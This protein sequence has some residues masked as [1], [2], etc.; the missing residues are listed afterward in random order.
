MNTCFR[1]CVHTCMCIQV[2]ICAYARV[3]I[4][5]VSACTCECMHVCTCGCACAYECVYTSEC[6]WACVYFMC[7]FGYA[8]AHVHT[9]AYVC[10]HVCPG[11]VLWTTVSA[12][13]LWE[14]QSKNVKLNPTPCGPEKPKGRE[15]AEWQT[16][17]G[18]Q[19]WGRESWALEQ[20]DRHRP[21]RS[22]VLL[23][24]PHGLHRCLDLAS[25]RLPPDPFPVS[26]S[27]TTFLPSSFPFSFSPLLLA[28]QSTQ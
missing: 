17:L 15:K 20:L 14:P 18:T 10:V 1:E 8:C 3:C 24:E 19:T 21:S 6:K 28:N 25:S 7:V 23:M 5:F 16:H 9:C 4:V 12:W 11:Y 27:P 22:V 13:L 26:C 2:Y